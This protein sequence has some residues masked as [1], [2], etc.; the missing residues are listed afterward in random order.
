[1]IACDTEL[2]DEAAPRMVTRKQK[3]RRATDSDDED[4]V[5]PDRKNYVKQSKNDKHKPVQKILAIK[6]TP[7][8]GAFKTVKS[9]P[10]KA[11]VKS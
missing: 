2:S 6:K 7:A 4:F 11:Y 1:M 5:E 10:K 9:D 8:T 3:K